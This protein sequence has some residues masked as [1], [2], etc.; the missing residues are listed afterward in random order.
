MT[1]FDVA[2]FQ[3]HDE[4]QDVAVQRHNSNIRVGILFFYDNFSNLNEFCYHGASFL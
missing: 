2:P 4:E 1:S 3:L